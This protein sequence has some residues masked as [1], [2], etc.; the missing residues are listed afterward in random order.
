MINYVFHICETDIQ[1]ISY[2]LKK[3]VETIENYGKEIREI[4]KNM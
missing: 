2:E 3:T 4:K 1:L